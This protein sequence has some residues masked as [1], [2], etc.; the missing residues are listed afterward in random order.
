MNYSLVQENK[1]KQLKL[2]YMKQVVE[3]TKSQGSTIISCGQRDGELH[4]NEYKDGLTNTECIGSVS[5]VPRLS[6]R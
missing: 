5:M 6:V 1:I 2:V 3:G 4:D